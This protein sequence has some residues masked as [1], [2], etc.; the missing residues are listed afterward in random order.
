MFGVAA[1]PGIALGLSFVRPFGPA[2]LFGRALW[3]RRGLLR[4]LLCGLFTRA[5]RLGR[6]TFGLGSAPLLK[7]HA[8]Y[9]LLPTGPR[10]F[11][12]KPA[13]RDE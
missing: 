10:A 7:R 6:R 2:L 13:T 4:T 8:R 9:R 12:H 5:L 3:L 11:E 1:S